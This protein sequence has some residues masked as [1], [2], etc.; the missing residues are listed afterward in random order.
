MSGGWRLGAGDLTFT[1]TRSANQD[2]HDFLLLDVSSLRAA[3]AGRMRRQVEN[4]RALAAVTCVRAS[5]MLEETANRLGTSRA[6][7]TMEWSSARLVPVLDVGSGGEEEL[8]D[9]PLFGRV[10]RRSRLGPRIARI[11]QRGGSTP[12][13]G[14]RVGAC[15]D[16]RSDGERPQ[17]C[18]REVKRR[19]SDVQ[20]MRNVLHEAILPDARLRKLRC[21]SYEPHRF[22]FI[23]DDSSEELAQRRRSFRHVKR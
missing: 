18:G 8:N 19:I 5:A 13:L 7:R 3:C 16:E 11:V 21:R 2:L 12:I 4:R 1:R 6:N 22:R 14:V 15:F 17:R 20:L 10:P 23:G 9:R